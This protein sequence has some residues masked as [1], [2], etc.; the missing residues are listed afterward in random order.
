MR[1]VGGKGRKG[2]QETA[3]EAAPGRV[4]PRFLRRPARILAK[5]EWS[6]PEH[7]GLKASAALFAL[8]AFAGIVLGG[9]IGTIAG[10]ATAKA[11]LAIESVKITGQVETSELDVLDGLE[12]DEGTSLVTYDVAA[13]R[14]RVETLAWVARAEI[15]K[16]YPD[17]LQV[18]IE[19]RLPYAL[20]QRGSAI[21]VI[22]RDGNVLSDFVAPR[23]AGLPLIVGEG[24]ADRAAK[25]MNMVEAYPALRPRMRAAVLVAGRRWNLVLDNGIELALPED[26]PSAALERIVRYDAETAL[27]GRD[28]TRVDLRFPDRLVVRLSDEAAKNREAMLKQR[29]KNARNA[30]ARL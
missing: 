8:T 5:M 27:L 30:G 17:T 25:F 18:R 22:D 4:L 14:E 2:R 1:A 23:Y 15:R 6:L 29:E 9:H 24:A 12:L 3:R 10:I 19:E 7:V 28:I 13:A 16:L 21:A 11:G 20:W 26:N